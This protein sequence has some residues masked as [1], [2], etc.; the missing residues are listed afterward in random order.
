MDDEYSQHM[1]TLRAQINSKY[2][3]L[4]FFSF[5]NRLKFHI[6]RADFE[7]EASDVFVEEQKLITAIETMEKDL[8]SGKVDSWHYVFVSKMYV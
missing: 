3:H 8:G 5:R 4:Y 7:D 6:H 1:K 2:N